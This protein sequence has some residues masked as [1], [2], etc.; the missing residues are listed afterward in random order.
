[1]TAE[2]TKQ[3]NPNHGQLT[4]GHACHYLLVTCHSLT[5]YALMN[6]EAKWGRAKAPR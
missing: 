4:L 6:C 1:M 2:K 3:R 5:L